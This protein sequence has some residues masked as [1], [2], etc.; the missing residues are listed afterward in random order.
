[1]FLFFNMNYFRFHLVTFHS[2]QNMSSERANF[3][4]LPK[5]AVG[6]VML[7]N[8][9][10][11]WINLIKELRR[12]SKVAVSAFCEDSATAFALRG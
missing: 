12:K 6:L 10:I 7:E 2:R 5:Y 1:M 4:R 11:R 8:K 9:V 3:L